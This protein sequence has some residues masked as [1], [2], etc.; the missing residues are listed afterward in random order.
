MKRSKKR[1]SFLSKEKKEY[2]AE[3]AFENASSE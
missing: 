2:E 3:F 1:Y